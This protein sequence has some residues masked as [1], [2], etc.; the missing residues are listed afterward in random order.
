MLWL[1]GIA[2]GVLQASRFVPYLRDIRAGTTKPHR[3]TWAIWSTL[4]LIVLFSQRAD[5]GTW[6]LLMVLT[7]LV[8]CVFIFVLS[9]RVGVGGT[10]RLEWGL[11]AIAAAGLVGWYLAGDPTVATLCVVLADVIAIA[12]MVPKTYRDPYSET[13]ST[14][15]LSL[16]S[17]VTA[18]IAVGSFELGLLLYP[19]YVV[20]ADV[21]VVA[22][23]MTRR[24]RV[25]QP[26]GA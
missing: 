2:S 4:S 25:A 16:L 10:S 26:S 13:L 11:L 23:M 3:G 20:L 12:L 8:G 6:S 21:L 5:G 1:F 22:I 7:Q 18:A 19:A 9:V 17:G 24:P 15:V 14:Y